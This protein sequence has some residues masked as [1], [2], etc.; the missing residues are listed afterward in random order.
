[1]KRTLSLLLIIC[2]L[3]S[4]CFLFTACGSKVSEKDLQKNPQSVLNDAM[5]NAGDEFFTDDAKMD[6]VIEKAMKKGSISIVFESADLMGGQITKI[7]ETIYM[8]GKDKKFVSDTSVVMGGEELAARIFLD[9]NG[10]ALNSEAVLGSNKTLALNFASF[11]EKFETSELAGMLELDAETMAQITSIAGTVKTELE[12][13]LGEDNKEAEALANELYKL[14]GQATASEKNDGSDCVVA[15]YTITN[16]NLGKVLKKLVD[17]LDEETKAQALES[18]DEMLE[19]M[20]D[21]ATINLTAKIYIGKK[22]NKVEKISLSGT[23][24][25]TEES[26]NWDNGVPTSTTTTTTANVAAD[27]TFSENEIAVN[28]SITGEDVETISASLKLTKEE[29]D[30]KVTYKAKIDVA[31]GSVQINLVNVAYAFEKSTGNFTLSADIYNGEDEARQSFE[32]AGKITVNKNDATIEINSLKMNSLTVTFK[33][34]ISFAAL[35]EIPAVPSDAKDVVTMTEA[36]WTEVMGEFQNST[37]GQ[38]IFGFPGGSAPEFD[39]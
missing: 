33:L 11:V 31:E 38:R 15:I 34:T 27:V 4:A 16:E 28:V 2:M 24:A 9:K 35:D 20:N 37:L 10:L 39:W 1:M 22:S 8:N 3:A 21:A 13:S 30:G 6:E 19:E 29:A 14:L 18:I 25:V 26:Y 23:V 5:Q 36:D 32:I 12:K 17:D 7:A